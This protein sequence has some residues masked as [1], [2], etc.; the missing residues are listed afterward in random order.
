M[1]HARI[2]GSL[3]TVVIG[4]PVAFLGEHF[5]T[6]FSEIAWAAPATAVLITALM[7]RCSVDNE[8]GRAALRLVAG[9]AAAVV[10]GIGFLAIWQVPVYLWN[11]TLAD[12]QGS[13]P[14]FR[15]MRLGALSEAAWED[16]RLPISLW[17]A[18]ALVPLFVAALLIVPVIRR[19]WA[20]SREVEYGPWRAEWLSKARLREL[21]RNAEGMPLGL[22]DGKICRFRSNPRR[23]WKGGHGLGMTGTRGGKGVAVVIP[24]IIDHAGPVVVVD[25]KGELWAMTHRYRASL[26][27]KVILL[28][29][30]A[31]T[32]GQSHRFNPLT[33]IRSDPRHVRADIAVVAEALVRKEEG[34]GEHFAESARIVLAAGIETVVRLSEPEN[35]TM[36][37]VSKVLFGPD[38]LGRLSDWQDSPDQVGID[39]AETAGMLLGLSDKERGS[40]FSTVRRGLEWAANDPMRDFL[41]SS[42]FTF[43]D[44]FDKKIDLFVAIPLNQLESQ[45]IFMRLI[46]NILLATVMR[47]A[48]RR[49]L[50]KN[51]L[52]VLDEFCRLGKME[53]MIDIATVANGLGLEALFIVQ[54]RSQLDAI[55]GEK[56]ANSLLAACATMRIWNLGRGDFATAEWL[57]KLIGE[58]TV[59]TASRQTKKF[60][61]ENRSEQRT[62]LLTASEILEMGGDE[63]LVLF[64]GQ[65]PAK[66]KPIISY[67]HKAYRNKLDPNPT[68]RL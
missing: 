41:S 58:K 9:V 40:F 36:A 14:I 64:D 35:R 62:P 60:G 20:G 61:W 39:V 1:K 28:D 26:D 21:T 3:F 51:V 55:Y 19:W 16:A 42:D 23:G 8:V 52:L 7:V 12:G 18:T 4:V 57:A 43:E 13:S 17:A 22:L 11:E 66:L 5:G 67:R 24:A 54:D 31:I 38:I 63:M 59:E 10:S 29:P 49:Q 15:A 46:I 45:S 65:R 30:F 56:G 68:L 50:K 25:I 37:A 34:S 44:F 53:K 48:G 2:L 47:E 33:F 27:R 6:P 32:I